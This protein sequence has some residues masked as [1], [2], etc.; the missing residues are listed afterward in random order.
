MPCIG[1]FFIPYSS[2]ELS[3][4]EPLYS[5]IPLNGTFQDVT[6]SIKAYDIL[7]ISLS[8]NPMG[9]RLKI[10]GQWT[11]PISYREKVCRLSPKKSNKPKFHEPAPF[12]PLP[13][14]FHQKLS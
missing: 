12:H 13:F 2:T 11:V 1:S 7:T 3:K 14:T 4:E 10:Q 6:Y 8:S 9:Q 5:A